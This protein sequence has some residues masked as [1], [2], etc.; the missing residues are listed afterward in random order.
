MGDYGTA[1][2]FFAAFLIISF[3]RSG[4]FATVFLAVSGAGLA[5]FLVLSIK[6]YIAQRFAAWGHVWEDP[7]GKG[8]QQVRAMSAAAS[9]GLVRPGGRQGLAP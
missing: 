4:S 5:G 6:P 2:I 8:F 3:L 9:G 1:V 7:L